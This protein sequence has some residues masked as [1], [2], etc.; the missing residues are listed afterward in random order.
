MWEL[1]NAKKVGTRG[2]L[3]EHKGLLFRTVTYSG[4]AAPSG[5]FQ[6]YEYNRSKR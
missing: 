4:Y 1:R 5:L 6:I 3:V 2:D